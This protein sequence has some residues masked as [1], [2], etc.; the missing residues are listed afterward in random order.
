MVA[1]QGTIHSL[2]FTDKSWMINRRNCSIKTNKKINILKIK[3]RKSEVNGQYREE[4]LCI[5]M[6]FVGNFCYNQ[7]YSKDFP[8][9]LTLKHGSIFLYLMEAASPAENTE[10]WQ[11]DWVNLSGKEY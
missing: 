2:L 8:Y 9:C 6:L 4:Q 7:Y 11:T 1:L 5:Q 10:P 3:L